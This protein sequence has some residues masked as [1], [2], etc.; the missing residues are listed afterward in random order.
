MEFLSNS[1]VESHDDSE[2]TAADSE[3]AAADSEITAEAEAPRVP[4][5]RKMFKDGPK[6]CCGQKFYTY[7]QRIKNF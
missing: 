5:K 2:I 3:I 6:I 7:D 4:K 1:A